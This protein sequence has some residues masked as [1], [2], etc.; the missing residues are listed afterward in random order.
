MQTRHHPPWSWIL[1]L[2]LQALSAIA[3]RNVSI[4]NTSPQLVYTPFLCNGTSNLPEG[5]ES[6]DGAW[7]T[8]V[9]AGTTVVTTNGPSAAAG[10]LIP[11]LFL[12]IRASSLILT[13]SRFSNA[14]ANLTLS[15]GDL[16]ISAQI[17]S[18]IGI[19]AAVNLIETEVTQIGI[20]FVQSSTPSR[21]DIGLLNIT[22]SDDNLPSSSILPSQT[23]PSSTPP[24][25]FSI[26]VITPT[27]SPSVTASA[28]ATAT[29]K[30][31]HRTMIAQAYLCFGGGGDAR[32]ISTAQ[33]THNP[34]VLRIEHQ[35]LHRKNIFSAVCTI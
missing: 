22:V 19:V 3:A 20:S 5:N 9:V 34:I 8:A 23:L 14:T 25:S 1:L 6:C 16:S 11:Q 18:S 15:A 24:P 13:T 21:L 30:T 2:A 31:P 28:T 35:Y 17:N 33:F 26:P 32:D 10:N 27:A 7:R 4:P 12:R 29:P